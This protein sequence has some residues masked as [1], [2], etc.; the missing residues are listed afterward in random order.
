MK[1]TS[2][3]NITKNVNS[4]LTEQLDSLQQYTRRSCVIVEGI[5]LTDNE[6]EEEVVV[7]LKEK[8]LENFDIS[9]DTL[10]QEFD[11]C[12]RVGKVRRDQKNSKS[13]Q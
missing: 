3:L 7:K 11:K 4:V 10:N 1:L 13:P 12:H 2:E 8:I 9:E 5:P 6:T